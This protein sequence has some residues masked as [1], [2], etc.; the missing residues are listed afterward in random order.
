MDK[1]TE[2]KIISEYKKGKSS[3]KI[4]KIVGLSK[5]T[6][7]KVLNKHNLIRK[8]DRCSKL[9]F[10]FDGKQYSVERV[11][12]NCNQTIQ[13]KSKDKTICC[14]NHLNKLKGSSLCKPCSLK[15]QTGEG[16]PF[17]GKK[18][19]KETLIKLSKTRKGKGTGND[20]AMSNPIWRKKV[21][22]NL[23]KKWN[24]GELEETRKLMSEH[25]KK[26]RRLGKIK[27]G[28]TSKKE[29]EIIQFLKEHNIQSIQSY[30]VDTKICDIY[31]SSLNL[32]IEYFGDYW[33]C[34]PKKYDENYFNQKKG[35]TAKQIWDYDKDKID[36]IRNFGYNLEVIWE[37][38]L[39]HD[40][41]KILEILNKYDSKNRF[42]PEWS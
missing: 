29:K 30:R 20:N 16:N 15:L 37:S 22:D 6:I 34:N 39:K 21:S 8:R 11:C 10:Q 17:Y 36:L 26:T 1:S 40:N 2:N 14:R 25:M 27:S 41:K 18:H 28:I 4:S 32:I 23:K 9:K 7:L 13:T 12:P 24:S 5:P 42:A 19:T 38:D 3:L 33:H 31:I 35:K